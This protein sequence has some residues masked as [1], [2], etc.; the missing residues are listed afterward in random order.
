[1]GEGTQLLAV[2]EN[3]VQRILTTLS[4]EYEISVSFPE[5][6]VNDNIRNQ[7]IYNRSIWRSH[8]QAYISQ[9]DLFP[10]DPFIQQFRTDLETLSQIN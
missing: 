4:S 9:L 3:Y 8:M 2:H 1:M 6:E 5:I 10:Q 7:F